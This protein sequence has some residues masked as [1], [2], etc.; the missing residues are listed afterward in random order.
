MSRFLDYFRSF[1]IGAA[2]EE[3]SIRIFFELEVNA[4]GTD[5]QYLTA[6]LP[7]IEIS[8]VG[9]NVTYGRVTFP[10]LQVNSINANYG[11]I[12]LYGFQVNGTGEQPIVCKIYP[13][14]LQVH[15]T[16]QDVPFEG[17]RC[18]IEGTYV[19]AYGGSVI[20]VYKLCNNE[21]WGL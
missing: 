6:Y 19:R 17:G 8:G 18:I 3:G 20:H 9:E 1:D 7:R 15:G 16:G 4:F 10:K 14:H 11:G 2:A 12:Q 13:I 21:N 5:G